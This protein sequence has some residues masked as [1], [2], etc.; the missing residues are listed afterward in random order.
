[1]TLVALAGTGVSRAQTTDRIANAAIV[2]QNCVEGATILPL[3][4]GPDDAPIIPVRVEGHDAAMYVS[5]LFGHLFVRN[6]GAIWFIQGPSHPMIAQDRTNA[7]TETTRVDTLEIGPIVLHDL[8]AERYDD[9]PLKSLAGRPIIGVIG[10]PILRHLR[11]MLMLDVPH[12]KLGILAWRDGPQCA[13]GP[14]GLFTRKPEIIDLDQEDR[15]TA[16]IDNRPVHIRLDPDL[17]RSALPRE[18]VTGTLASAADLEKDQPV[19]T[20]FGTTQRGVRHRFN[21]LRLGTR[22]FGPTEFLV[23][24]NLFDGALGASFFKHEVALIDF[25][26]GK[27]LFAPS[28]SQVSQPDL[29]LHFDASHEGIATVHDTPRQD[30]NGH[31]VALGGQLAHH[32]TP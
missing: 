5:P 3:L 17:V 29:G 31:P 4:G 10:R 24:E 7:P 28:T 20:K 11:L 22:D 2:A 19:V 1:M 26:H 30:M 6:A 27:F 13:A 25:H 8:V 23:L 15:I 12:E 32:T 18:T 14:E 9:G 16:F 21:D